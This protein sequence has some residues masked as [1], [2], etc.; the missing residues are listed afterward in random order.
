[1]PY[2]GSMPIDGGWGSA[3]D[4]DAMMKFWCKV[5][6]SKIEEVM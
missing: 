1:V 4:Q 3:T 6:K 5:N 2:N